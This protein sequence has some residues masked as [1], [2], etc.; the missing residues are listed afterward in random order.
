MLMLNFN[1]R[2]QTNTS[3]FSC[4]NYCNVK[5]ETNHKILF[6][7]LGEDQEVLLEILL[8]QWLCDDRETKTI[9]N[10]W[11]RDHI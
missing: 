7:K 5:L 3:I 4:L 2:I 9:Y 11:F 10:L 6:R 8:L 1:C